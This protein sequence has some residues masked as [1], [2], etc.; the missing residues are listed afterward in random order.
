MHTGYVLF[1]AALCVRTTVILAVCV[2]GLRLLGKHQM[3]QM[4]IYD[5]AM[6]MALANAVQNAMTKGTGDLTVGFACAG[7][8]LLAGKVLSLVFR[9]APRIEQQFAGIPTVL[10]MNGD[11]VRDHCRREGVSRDQLRTAV[12]EH[13]ITSLQD[14]RMAVLEVDGSISVVPVDKSAIAPA[15]D[16]RMS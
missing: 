11:V 15:M 14:V 13:G 10:I 7:I 6:I 3:A 8:L 5:L 16:G 1:L 2:I 12:R 4:N 9:N